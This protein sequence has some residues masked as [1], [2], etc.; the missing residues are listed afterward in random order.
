MGKKFLGGNAEQLG[1]E[2]R[3]CPDVNFGYRS[4]SPLANHVDRF[5]SFKGSLTRSETN[6]NPWLTTYVPSRTGG[7]AQ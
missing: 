3:L 7:P 4:Y 2:L 6:R 5:D 1:Y